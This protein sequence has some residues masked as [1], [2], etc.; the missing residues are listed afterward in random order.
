MWWVFGTN[1]FPDSK[2]KMERPL[3]VGTCPKRKRVTR[4]R[5]TRKSGPL[6]REEGED[7]YEKK[8]DRGKSA[9]LV[10]VSGVGKGPIVKRPSNKLV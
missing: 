3:S 10:G 4:Y 5:D 6:S 7:V 8:S 2:E 9:R 1:H